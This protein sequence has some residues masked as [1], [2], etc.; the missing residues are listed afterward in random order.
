MRRDDRR[1]ACVAAVAATT[2]SLVLPF[3]DAVDAE[4]PDILARCISESWEATLAA[5]KESLHNTFYGCR[6]DEGSSRLIRE[7]IVAAMARWHT[8]RNVFRR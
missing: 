3:Y 4:N 7:A 2:A 8:M 1:Q 5:E 6:P